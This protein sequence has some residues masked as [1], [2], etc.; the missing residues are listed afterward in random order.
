MSDSDLD[1][2]DFSMSKC[3]YTERGMNWYIE[4]L[5]INKN[6]YLGLFSI[7]DE[8]ATRFIM[9][10]K[11]WHKFI[12]ATDYVKHHFYS[13]LP[14]NDIDDDDDDGSILSE[15]EQYQLRADFVFTGQTPRTLELELNILM[16]RPGHREFSYTTHS[17]RMNKQTQKALFRKNN[18]VQRSFAQIK[19]DIPQ[20]YL[21]K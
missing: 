3:F 21:C 10:V 7:I 9:T 2:I 8:K 19:C 14:T 5:E 1:D 20:H 16:R 13:R 11:D 6:W 15:N 4:V 18:Y 12:E 17:I